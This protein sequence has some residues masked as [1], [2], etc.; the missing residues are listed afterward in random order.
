MAISE[1]K[2]KANQKWDSANMATLACKVKREQAAQFRTYCEGRGETVNAALQGFVSLCIGDSK[3]SCGA[4]ERPVSDFAPLVEQGG[5]IEQINAHITQTG[6]AAS[7]FV[8]RAIADTIK[9]D[10]M[11]LKMG[12]N[13]A[14]R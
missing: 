6:E 7:E 9:R 11:L 14:G 10:A 4:P 2:R 3:T 13:P 12:M 1:A 8:K 5:D